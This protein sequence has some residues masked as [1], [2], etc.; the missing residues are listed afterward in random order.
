MTG[1]KAL[2]V[3]ERHNQSHISFVQGCK[4]TAYGVGLGLV[5]SAL[6][7]RFSPA[8][9]ALSRPMQFNMVASGGITG[10]LIASERAAFEYKNKTL[11]Y[12]DHKTMDNRV[13]QNYKALP[14]N[15]RENTMRILNDNRWTILGATWATSMAGA[16]SYS[17]NVNK[18]LNL[19]QRLFHARIYAQVIT[20]AALIISA[21]LSFYVDEHDKKLLKDIPE[22]RLRA[23]LELPH[24]GQQKQHM[25]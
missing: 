2:T 9:R 24:V 15:S 7:F 12:V 10:Y 13:Y 3:P 16:Y 6:S 21:S 11:G 17:F 8:F 22:G 23:V 19:K 20:L 18:H 4:G 14:R 25:M 5:A 1:R